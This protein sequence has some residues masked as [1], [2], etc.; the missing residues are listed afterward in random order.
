M[1]PML[2]HPELIWGFA[3]LIV[4]M[5]VLDLWVF[6]K[7]NHAIS[8]KE[9]L[10]TSVVWISL[11]MIF[12]LVIL[13]I[14]GFDAFAK[15]QAAYWIEKSLSVDNLFVFILVFSFFKIPDKYQHEVLFYWVLWAIIF[16]AIFI[17]AWIGII[18]LTNFHIPFWTWHF[19]PILFIFGI[20]LIIAWFK[21]WFAKDWNDDEEQDIQKNIWYRF[22]K[23]FFK[24]TPNF[25]WPKFFTIENWI[26]VATPIFVALVVIEITD[27]VFAIDSIPAIFAIAPNEPFILYTSNIFAILGLRS[28]YFLL[29]NSL[30]TFSKLHYW[31][32]LILGF[33]GLKMILMPIY[34]VETWASLII[35]AILLI[36][37][38]IWS[39]YSNKNLQK[40]S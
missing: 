3:I 20:F 26:K 30:E 38:M 28:L 35:I 5:L 15:F 39:I 34:H 31:V 29:A 9:A 40:N 10:I 32:A 25:D 36:G 24:I 33:I 19:N 8:N 18:N 21:S 17:F 12:S 7:K 4:I 6:N 37:S 16:R 13:W 11:A 23:K 1:P 27:L 14:L 2:T 22:V